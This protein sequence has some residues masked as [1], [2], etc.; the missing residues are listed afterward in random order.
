MS[1]RNKIIASTPMI[2]LIVFLLLGFLADAWHPGWIVFLAIPIV[3]MLLRKQTVSAIYPLL[4]VIAYLIMGL[5]WN[6]WHPGWIIFL[7]IPVFE[8]FFTKK[9]KYIFIE[10]D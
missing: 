6:L 9:K 4:C 1:F 8:I 7:S 5:V 2:S 10:N 3:P